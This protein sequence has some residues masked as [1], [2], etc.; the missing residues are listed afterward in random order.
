MNDINLGGAVKVELDGLPE[1]PPPD[2]PDPDKDAKEARVAVATTLA[3][4][5]T[6]LVAALGV[7]GGL[8]GAVA[9]MARNY[10]LWT[11]VA[12]SA[13][14][15][16]VVLAIVARLAAPKSAQTTRVPGQ[17][18]WSTWLLGLSSV[19]FAGGLLLSVLLMAWTI[20]KDDRPS[21]TAQSTRD[22]TSKIASLSGSAKAGGLAAEDA[23]RVVAVAL[24]A[25]AT[26]TGT[27][28]YYAV[29]GPTPDGVVDHSF[30]VMLPDDAR[31]VVITVGNDADVGDEA[32]NCKPDAS[33]DDPTDLATPVE[34]VSAEDKLTA[35]AL[36][37][38]PPAP[39]G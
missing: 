17:P 11:A 2:P 20:G 12:L 3:T 39:S 33:V 24:P 21:L 15:L 30:T 9:R 26:E 35:C 36:V 31:S 7:F 37:A 10:P 22:A 14:I 6:V 1:P 5:V 27:Q 25:G 34:A 23:I 13:V 38:V 16:S 29:I 28:V 8:T 4:G 19:L 32:A 18:Y